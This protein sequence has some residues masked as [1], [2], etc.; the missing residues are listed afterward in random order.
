VLSYPISLP[1]CWPRELPHICT[2]ATGINCRD[3]EVLR[4][5]QVE[6]LRADATLKRGLFD[7][8]ITPKPGLIQQTEVVSTYQVEFNTGN[9]DQQYPGNFHWM[10]N[11]SRILTV[12]ATEAPRFGTQR[13]KSDCQQL[14]SVEVITIKGLPSLK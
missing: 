1:H 14:R 3:G 5:W 12:C 9:A 4:C 6:D 8:E 11:V 2:A 7:C 10:S 13:L